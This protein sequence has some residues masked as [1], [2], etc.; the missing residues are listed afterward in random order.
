MQINPVRA[1]VPIGISRQA[2]T[3]AAVNSATRLSG[4][5]TVPCRARNRMVGITAIATVEMIDPS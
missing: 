3:R 5:N 2:N 1:S 4:W